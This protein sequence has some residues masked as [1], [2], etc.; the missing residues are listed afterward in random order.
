MEISKKLAQE[1][2]DLPSTQMMDLLCKYLMYPNAP[3]STDPG[4]SPC[5]ICFGGLEYS[6]TSKPL[7]KRHF[8]C[9]IFDASLV[10]LS[11][12][13]KLDGTR[14][15]WASLM[16][17]WLG[18]VCLTEILASLSSCRLSPPRTNTV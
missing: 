6:F 8:I 7:F 12:F 11:N 16:T 10:S 1:L 13:S 18:P 5:P 3:H 14:F 15:D 2:M 17:N 4:S 9:S